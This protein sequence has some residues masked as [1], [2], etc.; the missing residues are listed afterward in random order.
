MQKSSERKATAI[1]LFGSSLVVG[2]L[3]FIG[4]GTFH[5]LSWDI[6]EPICYLMTMGNFTFGFFFYLMMKR[7][8]ELT[9]VHEILAYRMT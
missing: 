4:F 7:D 9:S 2:Q 3:G 8:L 6:M 5:Y 1:C